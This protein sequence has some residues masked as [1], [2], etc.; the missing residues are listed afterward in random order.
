VKLLQYRRIFRTWFGQTL[1]LVFAVASLHADS[2]AFEKAN[3]LFDDY[4]YAEAAEAYQKISNLGVSANLLFN[5]GNAYFKANQLGQAM[6]AYHRALKLAPRHP[7]IRKNLNFAQQKALAEPIQPTL[8]QAWLRNLSLGE[9]TG[10]ASFSS[11]ILLI[12][13]TLR[14]VK[15]T[16]SPGMIWVQATGG[17]TFITI[18]LLIMALLDYSGNKQAFAVR[19]GAIVHTGPVEQSPELFQATD[20]MEFVVL[21]HIENFVNVRSNNGVIGWI[22]ETDVALTQP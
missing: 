22:R 9:W 1:G 20:G 6:A 7:D 21:G 15:N 3:K 12:L 14:Q 8:Q 5:L 17:A 2:V 4:Q 11:T 10:L 19:D 16:N 18:L 13:M